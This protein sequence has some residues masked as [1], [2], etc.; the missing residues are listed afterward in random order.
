MIEPKTN[1]GMVISPAAVGRKKPTTVE[2]KRI[3]EISDKYFANKSTWLSLNLMLN[4][5][6]QSRKQKV[7]FCERSFSLLL[8]NSNC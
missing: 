5:L 8:P 2:A 4:I 6:Y 3:F 7:N 1:I